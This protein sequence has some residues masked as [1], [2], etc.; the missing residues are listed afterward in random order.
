MVI[1]VAGGLLI[2]FAASTVAYR[3]RVLRVPGQGILEHMD[4]DLKLTPA[5]H[6]QV[7][8]ILQDAR[9]KQ[10]Q[11]RQQMQRQR[12]QIFAQAYDQ[13]RAVL[14]PEQQHRFDKDFLPPRLRRYFGPEGGASGPSG[15]QPHA[16]QQPAE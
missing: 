1:A 3:Y 9:L 7:A 5:Q 6:D 16:T 4:R 8:D 15:P 10:M 11:V 13:I 12:R 14:T 2:G